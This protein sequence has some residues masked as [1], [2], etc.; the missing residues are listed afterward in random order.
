MKREMWEAGMKFDED[1]IGGY[2]EDAAHDSLCRQHG[3]VNVCIDVPFLHYGSGT[4]L[5]AD[6]VEKRRIQQNAQRNRELFKR[7]WGCEV[8]SPE[9]YT[10]LDDLLKTSQSVQPHDM[11]RTAT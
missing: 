6:P 9:Y 1:F 8:G 10:M 11:E 3:F 5:D 7:K 4:I 2:A